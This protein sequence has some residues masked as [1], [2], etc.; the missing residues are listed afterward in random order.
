M[1]DPSGLEA[2][3]EQWGGGTRK[4]LTEEREE[5]SRGSS[6]QRR[7]RRQGRRLPRDVSDLLTDA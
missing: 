7:G 4:R 5:V 2:W 6:A 1:P 3:G